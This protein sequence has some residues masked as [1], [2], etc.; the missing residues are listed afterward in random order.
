MAAKV[1]ISKDE[2]IN[3]INNFR[4]KK[5]ACKS[6]GVSMPTYNRLLKENNLEFPTTSICD[7]VVTRRRIRVDLN[8]EW[9]EKNWVNT[10]K[11]LRQLAREQNVDDAFL[12]DRAH[13]YGFSKHFKYSID[14]FKLL[15]FSDSDACYLAGL[16][17]TDGYVNTNAEFVSIVLVGDSEYQ[18]LSDILKVFSSTDIVRTYKKNNNSIRLSCLGYKNFLN[19]CFDI[20][21]KNKTEVVG[22]PKSF[23]SESCAKA[24]VLGCFDGDGCITHINKSPNARLLTKS[25]KLVYGIA[26]IIEYYTDVKVNRKTERGYPMISI[27]GKENLL[28]FL[29]WIYSS[30]SSLKLMRK[31][32]KYLVVKDIVCTAM[33]TK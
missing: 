17:A 23:I 14:E 29:D 13:R 21:S 18:L 3:S 22:V 12:Y 26:D 5:E 10:T 30:D 16:I 15:D 11:S 31:Y 6:V 19:E 24:Y 27:G 28:K 32:E 1:F 9:F 33:N 4:T 25:K 2:L 8:K 7:G 20:P